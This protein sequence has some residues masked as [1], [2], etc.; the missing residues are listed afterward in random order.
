MKV[1]K[2]NLLWRE[3]E[4]NM[5]TDLADV[6]QRSSA[7]AASRAADLKVEIQKLMDERIRIETK[8][9]EASREP[10]KYMFCFEH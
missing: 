6:C 8:L 4:Q 7:F 2:D 5:K 3:M 10:G 1:G 9:E